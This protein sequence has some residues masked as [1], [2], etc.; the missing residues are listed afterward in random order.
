MQFVRPIVSKLGG[1]NLAP[2]YLLGH[3]AGEGRGRASISSGSL[4][5][6][7]RHSD[8]TCVASV[9]RG[10]REERRVPG[11]LNSGGRFADLV[12]AVLEILCISLRVLTLID[13]LLEVPYCP[14][15]Q[16]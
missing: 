6:E 16:S 7:K 12:P 8:Q 10:L 4:V 9:S 5:D 15:L 2:N 3:T 11:R 13:I 1:C 14:Y